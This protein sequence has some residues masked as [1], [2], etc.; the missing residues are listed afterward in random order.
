MSYFDLGSHR[1]SVSTTSKEAQLWFDRGLNWCFGFNQEEGV[2][3]FQKAL[4]YDPQC[5]MAYWGIAYAAGPFYNLPWRHF[6]EEESTECTKF[7]YEQIQKARQ[8]AAS[9]SA[10]ENALVEALSF[11][12]QKPPSCIPRRF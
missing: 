12:F 5:V 1:K 6:G 7:C 3:C 10:L 11:R 8:Y 2:A 9:A 4:E